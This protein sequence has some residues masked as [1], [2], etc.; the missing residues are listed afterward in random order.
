VSIYRAGEIKNLKI[1][2]GEQPK[3][4]A[5]EFE[6]DYGFTAKE[7]TDDMYRTYMLETRDGVFVSFVDVGTV[8]D[9]GD[10]S[11]GDV[12]T[13]IDNHPTPDYKTFKDTLTKAKGQQ[14][15]LL[16][17]MRGKEHYLCLLDKD[18]VQSDSTKAQDKTKIA[19]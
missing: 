13:A 16:S 8:A 7:I 18:S 2:V 12:I 3:I 15:I 5:D 9:K 11:D 4:K 10:L 14:Y 19:Q 6:T 17:V 1:T